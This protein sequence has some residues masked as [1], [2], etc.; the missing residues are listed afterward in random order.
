[1]EILKQKLSFIDNESSRL[2]SKIF[3]IVLENDIDEDE[4]K[5]SS[6]FD[7]FISDIMNSMPQDRDNRKIILNITIMTVTLLVSWL[8][9][10]ENGENFIPKLES[11]TNDIIGKDLLVNGD[12]DTILKTLTDLIKDNISITKSKTLVLEK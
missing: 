11:L 3:T 12:Q 4:D 10:V 5:K 2:V 6:K 8:F 1:M 7:L 9:S